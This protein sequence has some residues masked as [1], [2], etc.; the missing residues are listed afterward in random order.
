MRR[1]GQ[2]Q[3]GQRLPQVVGVDQPE[4]VGLRGDP[5]R[6]RAEDGQVVG[7]PGGD[8]RRPRAGLAQHQLGDLPV[9]A[10]CLRREEQQGEPGLAP[11]RHADW[12]AVHDDGAVLARQPVIGHE[13]VPA[14]VERELVRVDGRAHVRGRDL[15]ERDVDV[16]ADHFGVPAEA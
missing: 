6:E 13:R 10:P 2:R 15:G 1:Q 7:I 16:A 11:A 14:P 3:A 5:G 4:L 12:R 8:V 9:V